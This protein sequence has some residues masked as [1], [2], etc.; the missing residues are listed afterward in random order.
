MEQKLP[1]QQTVLGKLDSYMQNNEA[2][3][4]PTY[5]MHKNKFKVD[6]RFKYKS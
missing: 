6:K 1:L 3:E 4:A 2:Q 5:T